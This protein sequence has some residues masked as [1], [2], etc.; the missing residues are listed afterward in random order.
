V[1]ILKLTAENVKKLKVVEI[2]PKGDLVQVTGKNGQGKSSVLDSIWWALAGKGSIQKEPVR[3]GADKG[4]IELDL[5]D[6]IVE[7]RFTKEGGST[8][9]VRSR[10]GATYPSP[11]AMLD[12]LIGDLSFDPLAF[13]RM[14]SKRQFEELRKIAQLE[15]DIEKLDG[16]NRTDFT[17]RTE[18]NRQEKA[19]RGRAAAI[20]VPDLNVEPSDESQLLSEL[21][22]AG[23]HNTLAESRKAALKTLERDAGDN[24]SRCADAMAQVARLR[25]EADTLEQRARSFSANADELDAQISAFTPLEPIETAPIRDRL[26]AARQTN[27]LIAQR[28]RKRSGKVGIVMED[29][30]VAADHQEVA[31]A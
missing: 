12:A 11:Q 3:R 16:L 29:G 26:Q 2:T 9:N 24:R 20:V 31:T 18:V 10:E 7:R 28:D 1:K 21:E 23:K 14:D 17:A 15:I 5:G 19:A 8:I 27:S 6:Y 22:E 25:D 4:R 30:A 13:S